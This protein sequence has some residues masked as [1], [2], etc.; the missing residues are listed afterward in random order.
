[1]VKEK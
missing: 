1:L